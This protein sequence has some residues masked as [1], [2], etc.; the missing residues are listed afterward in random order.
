MR[1][2]SR[3]R[4]GA[5]ISWLSSTENLGG[6]VRNGGSVLEEPEEKA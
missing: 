5:P 2:R 1:K 4:V 6:P 3:E